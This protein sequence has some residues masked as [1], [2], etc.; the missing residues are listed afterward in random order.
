MAIRLKPMHRVLKDTGSIYLHCDPSA[1]HYLKMLMDA[2]FGEDNFLNE[3]IWSYRTG[4]VSKKWW[5][6][7]HDV[8]L[9]YKKTN[10]Y[11]HNPL[12]ERV[13]YEKPFFT[14]K[15]DEYGRHYADVYIRDTWDDIKPL[16][17]T[18]KERMGYPT[19]KPLKLL[20]RII[21]ASCNKGDL[22]LDP[23]CGC[24]TTLHAAEQLERRWIGIDISQFSAGLVRN[25]IIKHF[26]RL[27]RG[28]VP[29]IGCPL[30]VTQARQLAKADEFEFEKW[31]CGEVGAE[32]LFHAPGQ[33]GPDGGVDGIIPFYHKK[34]FF[35]RAPPE[36]TFAVVQVKGGKV[37]PD[38]VKALSTTV[39]Q[40]GAKCGVFICFDKY[41]QTVENNREKGKI[42]DV[43]G[44]FNFIQ[45]FSVEQVINGEQPKLPGMLRMAA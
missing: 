14:S 38:S 32:G 35:D 13:I 29:V 26:K 34:E 44:E 40:T 28:N 16:I 4:G 6:K 25:R 24:G 8:I 18:S 7:K 27:N 15:V 23:F 43:T 3:I 2:I 33:K 21:T 42:K 1:S 22:V 31:A 10:K 5:P 19:Q 30:T 17:N 45:G 11:R 41:M 36:T 20:E 9:F 12:Q 39:R 37:T